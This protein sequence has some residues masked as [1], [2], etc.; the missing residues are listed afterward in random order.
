MGWQCVLTSCAHEVYCV[1]PD[2]WLVHRSLT[3]LSIAALLS[4]E[5]ETTG[6][7]AQM[8]SAE[9]W[10]PTMVTRKVSLGE[11]TPASTAISIA[12]TAA[13]RPT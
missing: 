13:T 5:S 11:A 9:Q 4:A 3:A 7:R 1:P 6:T 8:V 10:K 2:C 12:S